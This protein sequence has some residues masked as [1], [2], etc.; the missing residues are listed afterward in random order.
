MTTASTATV[1]CPI[2]L[3]RTVKGRLLVLW[4][5]QKLGMIYLC[6]QSNVVL[7]LD[8]CWG[9]GKRHSC[10]KTGVYENLLELQVRSK[11]TESQLF[12][13]FGQRLYVL[14][15]FLLHLNCCVIYGK[16][17]MVL[18]LTLNDITFFPCWLDWVKNIGLPSPSPQILGLPSGFPATQTPLTQCLP[19]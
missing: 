16:L 7:W 11:D 15:Y 5:S 2:P 8:S 6:K 12:K 14:F 10:I 3:L 9:L 19:A 4:Q 13:K 18:Y 1:S 17:F